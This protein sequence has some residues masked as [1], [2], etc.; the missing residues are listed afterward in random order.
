MAHQFPL[1]IKPKRTLNLYK[2]TDLHEP[3][4]YQPSPRLP[5][6]SFHFFLQSRTSNSL[7]AFFQY[8]IP[9][10]P[11]LLV[12]GSGSPLCSGRT[13]LV[14]AY[15]GAFNVL[16]YLRHR[17]H[18]ERGHRHPR[19]GLGGSWRNM[20]CMDIVLSVEAPNKPK[21]DR[22]L[23]PTFAQQLLQKFHSDAWGCIHSNT[24][25]NYAV[26]FHDAH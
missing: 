24:S 1:L 9:F 11:F 25:S 20:E 3:S 15:L 19:A 21:V 17:E 12:W 26:S 5:I 13:S 8:D 16:N 18:R 6:S 22:A 4:I 10:I 2:H 14:K 23:N 7:V